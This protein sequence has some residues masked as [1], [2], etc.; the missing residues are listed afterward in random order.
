MVFAKGCDK[1]CSWPL[2]LIA[3]KGFGSSGHIWTGRLKPSILQGKIA[4]LTRCSELARTLLF[5]SIKA[6]NNDSKSGL[7]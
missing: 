1:N 7:V 6:Q 2:T 3:S 5:Y 4:L